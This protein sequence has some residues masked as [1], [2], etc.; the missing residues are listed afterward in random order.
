[1]RHEKIINNSD[2]DARER[3]EILEDHVNR[4]VEEMEHFRKMLEKMRRDIKKE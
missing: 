3:I 1:M 4:L 2:L